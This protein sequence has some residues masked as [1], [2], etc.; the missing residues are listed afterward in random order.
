MDR[1]PI[2]ARQVTKPRPEDITV[3]STGSYSKN[4]YAEALFGVR[5]S[6]AVYHSARIVFDPRR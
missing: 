4:E 3:Y 1:D 2:I 6:G 5:E